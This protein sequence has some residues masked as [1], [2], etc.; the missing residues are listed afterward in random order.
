M[1]RIYTYKA[2]STCRHAIKWLNT[3]NI[4]FTELPIRVTPPTRDEL[5]DML[6]ARKGDLRPL[7]NTSSAD[8]REH[9]IKN[10]LAT[11][12]PD[13]AFKLMQSNGN[14]VKRP[15]VIDTEKNIHLVGFKEPEWKEAF[16]V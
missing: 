9:G 8:Y 2:C 10:K 4:P 7:F 5:G 13:A 14:L 12:T 1:L 3:N 6:A 16:G 11:I 15:F